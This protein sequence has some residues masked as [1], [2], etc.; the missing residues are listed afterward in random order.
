MNNKGTDMVNTKHTTK[1]TPQEMV[2]IAADVVDFLKEKTG[3]TEKQVS[4]REMG[5]IIQLAEFMLPSDED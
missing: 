3:S 5:V 4:G 2:S 1:L